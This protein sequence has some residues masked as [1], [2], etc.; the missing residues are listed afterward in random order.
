MLPYVVDQ[1]CKKI[2]KEKRRRE[3][4]REE[5]RL[6]SAG[7]KREKKGHTCELHIGNERI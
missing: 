5:E 3:E 2:R 6:E 1:T 4:K 7:F